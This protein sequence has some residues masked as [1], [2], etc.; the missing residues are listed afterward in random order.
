ML[1]RGATKPHHAAAQ[2]VAAA[3]QQGCR[4]LHVLHHLLIK[5]GRGAQ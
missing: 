3:E 1:G 4:A 2:L 5:C